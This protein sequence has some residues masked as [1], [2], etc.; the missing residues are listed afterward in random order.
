MAKKQN[1]AVKTARAQKPATAQQPDAQKPDVQSVAT[2]EKQNNTKPAAN[3]TGKTDR[4]AAVNIEGFRKAFADSA[5]ADSNAE[6]KVAVCADLFRPIRTWE[7]LRE[8]MRHAIYGYIHG[9]A[10]KQ[11]AEKYFALKKASEHPLYKVAANA[12]KRAKDRA[13]KDGWEAPQAPN[14]GIDRAPREKKTGKGSELL[15]MLNRLMATDEEFT[16]AL[17]YAVEN[18]ALFK[19]WARSSSAAA[20]ANVTLRRVA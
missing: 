6:N 1:A 18:E 7:E 9:R 17:T 5:R 12:V 13:E 19:A 2:V 11:E 10:G 20:T 4:P 14:A 15:S 16:T 8:A 3:D